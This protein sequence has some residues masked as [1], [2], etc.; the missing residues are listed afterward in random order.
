MSLKDRRISTLVTVWSALGLLAGFA[1]L[2]Y[3]FL[4]TLFAGDAL[5]N[6]DAPSD[7]VDRVRYTLLGLQYFSRDG[8]LTGPHLGQSLALGWLALTALL[9]WGLCQPR[10]RSSA[11]RVLRASLL[12]LALV[13]GG[14]GLILALAEHRHNLLLARPTLGLDE[15]DPP[16]MTTASV[17]TLDASR[18]TR[19]VE[20]RGC[21]EQIALTFPN[22]S[23]WG[24]LAVF[25]TA[26]VGLRRAS[27]VGET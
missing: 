3:N 15:F 7:G 22:P 24:A 12:S 20:N 14:G 4:D 8:P 13:G 10:T 6:R 18:C 27:R 11:H 9:M 5:S 19:W 26:G 23:L 2:G 16:G 25:V 17:A 21:A 1:L